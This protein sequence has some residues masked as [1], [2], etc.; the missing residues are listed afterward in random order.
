MKQAFVLILALALGQ[1]AVAKVAPV[2]NPN[3]PKGGSIT[4][5]Y[6]DYPKSLLMYLAFEE[7]AE[8]INLLVLESLIEVHPETYEHIP[9]L[10]KSWEISGDK[11]TYTF[12]LDERAR[13]SDGKPVTAE[14]VKFTWDTLMNPKNKTA[15]FQ[16][17]YSSFESCEVVDP[18]TVRFKAK[19]C[20]FKNLEK[21][22]GLAVLPKHVYSK[23]NFNKDFN[24]KLVG[25]GP[26]TLHKIERGQRIVLKRNP[27]Y[28][29]ATL[30]QNVGKYNFDEVV[31]K[32]VSDYN[33]QFEVF[34]RGDID[35]FY[36]LVAK[37]WAEDTKG[38]LFDNNY[39][40]KIKG[41]NKEP[42]GTQGIA[43]NLRK[44]LF[45]D[46]RV[47][48]ALSHLQNREKWIKELFFGQYI[49][50]TGVVPPTSEYHHPDNR[51]IP[52]D[53]KR[54]KAL[55]AEAGWT[56]VGPDG[57]LVKDGLRF[58]FDMLSENQAAMR[59]LT[60]YQE[61][62][63]KMG[64]K[65]NIRMVDWATS[66]K[67]L[68]DRQFDAHPSNRGRAIEPSDF[69]VVWG[70]KE[71]D[72]KGSANT[73]GYKNPELDKLAEEIDCTFEKKKRIPLVQK[74]D[75]M[76]ARDQPISPAWEPTYFRVA[77]WNKFSYPGKGYFNYTGW[78]SAFHYWWYDK[79]K[80]G[81]LKAA[82]AKNQKMSR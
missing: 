64:I 69:A 34:K 21:L 24:N 36:F 5:G 28:W 51:P 80:A 46:K 54:A 68:D 13:F 7:L 44:P 4:I 67:L 39:I 48:L 22:G 66:L 23:G 41:Q 6:P 52:Y 15:P 9:G 78:K 71:A 32:S 58:E 77:H 11:T 56:K 82:M 33:V 27:G 50:S 16:A 72:I 30:P 57:V 55:L 81:K 59:Y 12:K 8:G 61:D 47:R 73:T 10:A 45:Q 37:M 20:H 62:L 31:F 2:G 63:K 49:L 25:S 17:Y 18:M 79:D 60:Q 26:Y 70:S 29:G 75:L 3:A 1:G 19:R 74:I 43:W 38:P 14:D 53:P 35:Y 40:V 42:Y 76:I 65:M